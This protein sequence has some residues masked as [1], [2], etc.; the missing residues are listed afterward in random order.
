MLAVDLIARDANVLPR[1]IWRTRA[2]FSSSVVPARHVCR[3]DAWRQTVGVDGEIAASQVVRDNGDAG[4]L[5]VMP[6]KAIVKRKARFVLLSK[7]AVSVGL[8]PG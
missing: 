1:L 2:R 7:K 8:A 6:A 5:V 3:P 4:A